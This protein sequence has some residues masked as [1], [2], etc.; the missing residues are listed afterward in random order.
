HPCLPAPPHTSGPYPFSLSLSLPPPL[1]LSLSSTPPLSSMVER[2]SCAF[3]NLPFTNQMTQLS[4]TRLLTLLQSHIDQGVDT[5]TPPAHHT[6]THTHTTQPTQTIY[7]EPIEEISRP[8]S[9]IH[10]A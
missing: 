10:C 4:H 1:S 8:T 9:W 3:T 6:H 7:R 5:H 2:H